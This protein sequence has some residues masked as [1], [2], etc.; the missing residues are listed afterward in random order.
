MVHGSGPLDRNE[1]VKKGSHLNLFNTLAHHLAG[2]G[3]ASLRYDKRGC[4]ESTGDYYAA[5]HSDLLAD[6]SISVEN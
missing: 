5:G 4:G 2:I 1:N 6:V 3:I